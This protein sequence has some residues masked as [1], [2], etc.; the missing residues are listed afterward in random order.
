MQNW[1]SNPCATAEFVG[2]LVRNRRGRVLVV[3]NGCSAVP[4]AL[5]K[6][7]FQHVTALDSC[8]R[9]QEAQMAQAARSASGADDDESL[10]AAT[11]NWLVGDVR[12][13]ALFPAHYFDVIVDKALSDVLLCYERDVDAITKA[14][15]EFARVLSAGGTFVLISAL[16]SKGAE[17]SFAQKLPPALWDV[18]VLVMPKAL[19]PASKRQ[20]AA[21]QCSVV[22]ARRKG[23]ASGADGGGA[24]QASEEEEEEE[25]DDDEDEGAEDDEDDE[26]EDDEDD[27]E[28]EE[29]DETEEEMLERYAE[30]A[31]Q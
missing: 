27:E 24:G 12:D 4:I 9:V 20:G 2:Q 8:H 11:V 10:A 17:L 5:R 6:Q 3:G 13:L 14:Y 23:A 19:R 25:E 7:G 30:I 21:T 15:G 31:R 1:V 29:D 28:E 16:K 18:D 26:D 22:L